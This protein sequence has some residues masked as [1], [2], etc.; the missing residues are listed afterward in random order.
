MGCDFSN[1]A[2][3]YFFDQINHLEQTKNKIHRKQARI[4]SYLEEFDELQEF[5]DETENASKGLEKSLRKV[6]HV[7][8]DIQSAQ[9]NHSIE[10]VDLKTLET[11][12]G[13]EEN[14]STQISKIGST[15]SPRARYSI[16]K[17]TPESILEDPEIIAMIMKNRN[18]L[19]RQQT[20]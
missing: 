7:L 16:P 14:Q 17:L 15:T 19:L 2:S 3:G 4:C 1:E 9:R 12:T 13:N 10:V 11:K 20:R 5:S 18:L 6:K 8:K